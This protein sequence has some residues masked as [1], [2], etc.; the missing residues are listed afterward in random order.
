MVDVASVWKQIKICESK[1]KLKGKFEDHAR[2]H[3][4]TSFFL[5]I[6]LHPACSPFLV[7]RPDVVSMHVRRVARYIEDFSAM[8]D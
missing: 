3:V 7:I 4:P 5:L 2:T 1:I 6:C 8:Y